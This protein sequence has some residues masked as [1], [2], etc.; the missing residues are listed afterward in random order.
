MLRK[1]QQ[2]KSKVVGDNRIADGIDGRVGI[3]DLELVLER[4][5]ILQRGN[6]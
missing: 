2:I 3:V 5:Q 4:R 6:S 1:V